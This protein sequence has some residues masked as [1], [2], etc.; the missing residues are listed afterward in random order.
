MAQWLRR[1]VILLEDPRL[2]HSAHLRKLTAAYN[3]GP[4]Y[5]MASSGLCICTRTQAIL[6]SMYVAE[7]ELSVPPG[8]ILSRLCL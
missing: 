7:D 2:I 4:G 6:K 8:S 5:M 3:Q 1:L